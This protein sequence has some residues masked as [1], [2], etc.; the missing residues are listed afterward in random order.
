[1]GP[2][3][4]AIRAGVLAMCEPREGEAGQGDER[5]G[6]PQ[7]FDRQSSSLLAGLNLFAVPSSPGKSPFPG[8]PRGFDSPPPPMKIPL[9]TDSLTEIKA[10]PT[11]EPKSGEAPSPERSSEEKSSEPPKHQK[12]SP[13][14][15]T[16]HGD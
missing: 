1:M 2:A 11:V 4:P 8:L 15:F 10:F 14:F 7:R 16:A 13:R 6:S 12:I 5:S 9:R 3:V